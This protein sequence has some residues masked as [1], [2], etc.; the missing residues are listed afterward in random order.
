MNT[1]DLI[2]TL[3]VFSVIALFA[4][5]FIQLMFIVQIASEQALQECIERDFDYVENFR[6]TPFNTTAYGV[7]CGYKGYDRK[8]VDIETDQAVAIIT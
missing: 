4:T 7:E 1:G 8:R 2:F 3:F 5:V 6:T